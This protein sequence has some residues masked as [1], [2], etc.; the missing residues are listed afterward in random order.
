MLKRCLFFVL[1]LVGYL[2]NAQYECPTLTTPLDGGIDVAVN[3][4]ISWSEVSG[5]DGYL[6][7]LGTTPGGT[8]I[9]DN[10]TVTSASFTPE[11]GLPENTNIYVTITLFFFDQDNVICPSEMFR[12][13]NVTTPPLCTFISVP[14]DGATDVF[15]NTTIAWNYAPTASGYL[16]SLGTV[17][18]GTDIIDNAIILD[19]LSYEPTSELPPE[20]EVFVQIIP[21]N[22]NGPAT[23]VCQEFSF[24]TEAAV[25]LPTCAT[26]ISPADGDI[27]VPLTPLLE[28][29]SVPEADGYRVSIGTTP[30][31]NNILDN[32]A[33]SNNNTEVIDF[34]PNRRY[35]VTIIPFNRA[36]DAIGCTQT[37]FTTILGCGPV[38]DPVTGEIVSYG[39]EIDFP[40]EVA[41]CLNENPTIITSENIAQGHRWY[42]INND[43][44]ETLLSETAVLSLSELGQYRYEA[45]N[46]VTQLGDAFECADSKVFFV[47]TSEVASITAVDVVEQNGLLRISVK[48]EGVGDYEYAIDSIDGPYRHNNIFDNITEG[49]HTIYVRDKNGCGIVQEKITEGLTS[50]GFP[51]FFTPNGDG[52]ND[53]WQFNSP[54]ESAEAIVKTIYIFDRYGTLVTQIEPTSPGWDG[55][56]R[57][58]PLPASDYWYKA[59]ALNKKEVKGHFA[60]KR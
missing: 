37:S 43:A 40:S 6:I 2:A 20:T 19:V 29:N 35:Y 32:G 53:F 9:V 45:Y 47:T 58:L 10:R 15:T 46:L 34:L 30:S 24:I 55:N 13:E 3:V 36:G 23:L 51:T 14:T 21:F 18:G 33:Y 28:W 39:P 60:L 1:I 16:L 12:T 4:E 42:K 52:I 26:L 7:S 41:L 50:E 17:S 56:S 48:V 59:I 8:D 22:E 57:G 49:S 54:L 31:D 25:I 44:T 27:N 38:E 11:L 5:I